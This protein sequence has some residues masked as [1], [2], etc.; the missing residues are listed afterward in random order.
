[1]SDRWRRAGHLRWWKTIWV[2]ARYA[3]GCGDYGKSCGEPAGD[4][5]P[6]GGRAKRLLSSKATAPLGL[7]VGGVWPYRGLHATAAFNGMPTRVFTCRPR[8]LRHS[9]L[10]PNSTGDP[11]SQLCLSRPKPEDRRLQ[12]PYRGRQV[13]RG[14]YAGVPAAAGAST[15]PRHSDSDESDRPPRRSPGPTWAIQMSPLRSPASTRPS[16]KSNRRLRS[17]VERPIVL[18]CIKAAAG[19]PRVAACG[20]DLMRLARPAPPWCS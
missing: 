18:V 4:R 7:N 13:E 1:M 9:P 14:T 15:R 11:D 20:L 12:G 19:T 8:S 5:R 6:L 10:T 16:D 17:S 3:S 2:S